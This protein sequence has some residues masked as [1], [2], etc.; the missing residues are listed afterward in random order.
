[1]SSKTY[2]VKIVGFHKFFDYKITIDHTSMSFIPD[3]WQNP[4][5]TSDIKNI[6]IG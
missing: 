4:E 5:L 1:M 3:K 6:Q 2:K